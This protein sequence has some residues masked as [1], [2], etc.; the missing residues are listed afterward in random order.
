[1]RLTH[2]NEMLAALVL[3][4][5]AGRGSAQPGRSAGEE[6]AQTPRAPRFLYAASE[7]SRPVPIDA[8]RTT[9]LRRNISLHLS[10]ATVAR[11][12]AE[13]RAQSGLVLW[14]DDRLLPKAA[15]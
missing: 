14:Y 1:M 10:D 12:L 5:A 2:R 3:V 7:R 4:V 8:T 13:I 11:G 15:R 9:I 6:L